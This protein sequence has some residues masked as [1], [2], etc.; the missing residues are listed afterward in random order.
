LLSPVVVSLPI[1]QIFFVVDGASLVAGGPVQS[2]WARRRGRRRKCGS[3]LGMK[4]T[5][6]RYDDGRYVTV[7]TRDDGVSYRLK[8]VA[9]MFAIPHDPAH[10][11]VEKTLHLDRGFWGNVAG[12]AVFKTK[13]LSRRPQEAEGGRA[14]ETLLKINAAPL[15]E[16]RCPGA[17]FQRHHR[18]G[19]PPRFALLREAARAA[20]PSRTGISPLQ[21][22]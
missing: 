5:L 22:R 6:T 21:R 11:L 20:R 3:F 7:I 14:V 19:P 12:G 8:G 16:A 10:F 17:H 1:Q 13:E 2:Y 18:T 15:N 4:L 9:H